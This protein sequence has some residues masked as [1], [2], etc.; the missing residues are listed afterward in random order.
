MDLT[1]RRGEANFN[2]PWESKLTFSNLNH[3][4]NRPHDSNSSTQ[5][6]QW[7]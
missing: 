6:T 5:Q 4:I 1:E 7:R 3:L 2:D